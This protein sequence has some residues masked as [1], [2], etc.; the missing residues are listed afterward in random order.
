V[1]RANER[2]TRH[3]GGVGIFWDR[4]TTDGRTRNPAARTRTHLGTEPIWSAEDNPAGWTGL[5]E[6][7]LRREGSATR[8]MVFQRG[9][10]ALD[11]LAPG[12]GGPRSLAIEP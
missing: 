7:Y 3:G 10:G 12:Q 11:W 9:A 6:K 5:I 2:G 1:P 8:P 4:T